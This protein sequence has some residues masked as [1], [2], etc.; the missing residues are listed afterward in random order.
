MSSET[1]RRARHLG[2]RRAGAPATSPSGPASTSSSVVGLVVAVLLLQLAFIGSYV[3]A[4]HD[5]SPHDVRVVVVGGDSDA[6]AEVLDGLD[7]HPVDV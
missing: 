4:F 2:S 5:P 7:G 3:G 1:V 6:A